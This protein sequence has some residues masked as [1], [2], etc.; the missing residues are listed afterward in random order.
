M[1]GKRK[2]AWKKGRNKGK[3]R[4]EGRKGGREEGRKKEPAKLLEVSDNGG[5][6]PVNLLQIK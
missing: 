3:G 5:N 4:K 6:L 2:K 1:E